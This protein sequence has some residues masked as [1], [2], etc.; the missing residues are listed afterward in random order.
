VQLGVMHWLL[1]Q[2]CVELQG[3]PQSTMLPHPSDA[4][5]HIRFM[6]MQVCG[7][8]VAMPQTFGMPDPPHACPFGQS[9][10]WMVPPQ[11]SG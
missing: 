3:L 6:L 5:P 7:E 9:P 10:Q 1:E 8:Q 11:L 2:S 4:G